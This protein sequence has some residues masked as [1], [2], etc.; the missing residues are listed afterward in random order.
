MGNSTGK[1]ATALI[2]IAALGFGALPLSLGVA[3]G[4]GIPP[5]AI[6]IQG[7][8]AVAGNIGSDPNG[9]EGAY[10]WTD[11]HRARSSITY[12]IVV[13]TAGFYT[14]AFRYSAGS[15]GQ[16]RVKWT[17]KTGHRSGPF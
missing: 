1:V 7:E 8:E 4:S 13:E 6:K 12:R 3:R 2:L 16:P 15:V 5:G 14:F 11:H 10:A 17:Q 9:Q